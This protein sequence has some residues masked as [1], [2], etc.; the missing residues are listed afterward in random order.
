M[1]EGIECVNSE[2]KPCEQTLGERIVGSATCEVTEITD[3]PAETCK[4]EMKDGWTQGT[5]RRRKEVR[6]N[7]SEGEWGFLSGWSIRGG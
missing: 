1:R 6:F 3:I 2:S 5:C 7:E 4:F